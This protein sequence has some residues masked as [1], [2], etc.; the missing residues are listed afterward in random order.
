TFDDGPDARYTPAILDILK[1]ENVKAAFFVLGVNGEDNIPLLR[2]LAEEGHD[3]GNHTFTHPNLNHINARRALIEM[4]AN[5]RLIECI[6]G[7]STILYRPPFSEDGVEQI[8]QQVLPVV[9]SKH[10]HYIR[11]GDPIDSKDWM[12]ESTSD[13]IMKHIDKTFHLGNFILMHDGGGNR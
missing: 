13:S 10:E 7:K 2:R 11:I 6:T 5:K 3:I 12:E 9:F 8:G 4:R 1:K